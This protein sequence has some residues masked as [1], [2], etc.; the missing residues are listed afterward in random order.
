MSDWRYGESEDDAVSYRSYPA[1]RFT[2]NADIEH[3][4]PLLSSFG[5]FTIKESNNL[6]I[7]DIVCHLVLSVVPFA[8]WMMTSGGPVYLQAISRLQ[9]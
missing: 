6:V 8:S 4:L 1:R 3:I 9:I 7:L 2:Y 5:L